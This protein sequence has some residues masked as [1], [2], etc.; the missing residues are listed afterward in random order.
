[1]T[2]RA[3]PENLARLSAAEGVAE[4]DEWMVSQKERLRAQGPGTS[5]MTED[6]RKTWFLRRALT[7]GSAMPLR[8]PSLSQRLIEV[9]PPPFA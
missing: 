3:G 8:G 6:G 2:P 4:A 9:W 5:G 7:A 1:M